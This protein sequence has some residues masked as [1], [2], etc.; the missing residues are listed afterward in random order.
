MIQEDEY[1]KWPEAFT[2]AQVT[3]LLE[4]TFSVLLWDDGLYPVNYILNKCWLASS[5]AGSI[6]GTTR[7]EVKAGQQEQENSGKR[8][9]YWAVLS[10]LEKKQD[11]TAS[12]KKLLTHVVNTDKNNGLI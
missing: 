5:Q 7:Q 10:Q 8:K 6:G 9:A 11:V 2:T 3:G 1:W 4:F 12:L